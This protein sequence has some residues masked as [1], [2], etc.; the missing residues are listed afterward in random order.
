MPL[1][2]QDVYGY[3]SF[4]VGLLF[5]AGNVPTLFGVFLDLPSK[6]RRTVLTNQSQ[7]P[8]CRAGCPTV[9]VGESNGRVSF[10]LSYRCRGGS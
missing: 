10:P 8:L 9:S 2:L 6:E 7:H 3:N 1:R 5:M 4:Q